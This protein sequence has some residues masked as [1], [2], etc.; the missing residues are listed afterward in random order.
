MLRQRFIKAINYGAYYCYNEASS[1]LKVILLLLCPVMKSRPR[2]QVFG[3][4][5]IVARL[6]ISI[7]IPGLISTADK[8]KNK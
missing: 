8:I 6:I 4:R 3:F 2:L 5:I 7:N 1:F